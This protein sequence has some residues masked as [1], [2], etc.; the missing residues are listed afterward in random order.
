MNSYP[1]LPFIIIILL[2]MT[3]SAITLA[4][5]QDKLNGIT[6]YQH[7]K[8]ALAEDLFRQE[9]AR[10]P[11]QARNHYNLG[12]A[13]FRQGKLAQARQ[14]FAQ[15]LR[16]DPALDQARQNLQISTMKLRQ[17]QATQK[18]GKQGKQQK[19]SPPD[20]QQPAPSCPN[21]QAK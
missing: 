7:K 10:H 3:C 21:P 6:A 11:Q 1:R 9:I 20:Q 17:Q 16:L 13:L 5:E 14:A 12:T 4:A 18:Q 8:F 15:A 19:S 2:S